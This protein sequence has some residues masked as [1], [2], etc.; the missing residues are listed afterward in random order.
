MSSANELEDFRLVCLT[1]GLFINSF[2]YT[3]NH[4]PIPL[5][6]TNGNNSKRFDDKFNIK[7]LLPFPPAAVAALH[8]RVP[9]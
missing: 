4:P 9:F 7:F 8:R 3:S 1:I 2:A 6:G 5:H